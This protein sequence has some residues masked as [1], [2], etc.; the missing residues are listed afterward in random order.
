MGIGDTTA[1]KAEMWVGQILRSV[2][3]PWENIGLIPI[4]PVATAEIQLLELHNAREYE[5]L[6]N[7]ITNAVK[8]FNMGCWL[9]EGFEIQPW[10]TETSVAI[11]PK[12]YHTS[13]LRRYLPVRAQCQIVPVNLEVLE[14]D[15]LLTRLFVQQMPWSSL[16]ARILVESFSSSGTGRL[17][18]Y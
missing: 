2:E 3:N 9:S 14:T 7:A 1:N 16:S 10:V 15:D 13:I 12:S 6:W 8:K 18:V 17:A 5:D 4:L 11:P